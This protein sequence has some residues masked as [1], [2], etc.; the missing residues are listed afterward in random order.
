[1]KK[2]FGG[3]SELGGGNSNAFFMFT[4]IWVGK[5]PILTYRGWGNHQLTS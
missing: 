3:E 1:M 2:T 4:P 5:I